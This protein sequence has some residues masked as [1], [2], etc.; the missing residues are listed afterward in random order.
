[1]SVF[2][3]IVPNEKQPSSTFNIVTVTPY[4][5]FNIS[6]YN[7]TAVLSTLVFYVDKL[8]PLTKKWE[9]T[10]ANHNSRYEKRV[11]RRV[12]PEK[13]CEDLMT[14][15][16]L[17]INDNF[18]DVGGKRKRHHKETAAADTTG[19]VTSE[20]ILVPFESNDGYVQYHSAV[21]VHL[22]ANS[23]IENM[24]LTFNVTSSQQKCAIFRISCFSSTGEY[25]TELIT[26]I[27]NGGPKAKTVNT[28]NTTHLTKFGKVPPGCDIYQFL[29]SL[30]QGV[31]HPLMYGWFSQEVIKVQIKGLGLRVENTQVIP[32]EVEVPEM[33]AVMEDEFLLPEDVMDE[34][35]REEPT[36]KKLKAMD[37]TVIQDTEM[38]LPVDTEEDTE[39]FAT[40]DAF[41]VESYFGDRLFAI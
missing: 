30:E 41:D 25:I 20:S 2:A 3:T 39:L 12:K 40:E 22:H 29:T 7:P 35:L 15:L 36:A 17:Q 1:M 16:A 38:H 8:S 21:Q 18:E 33:T 31:N 19:F 13:G 11:D 9:P 23:S 14:F 34:F 6:C 26:G 37:K 4:I 28:Y 32:E 27:H 5:A 24:R 10:C